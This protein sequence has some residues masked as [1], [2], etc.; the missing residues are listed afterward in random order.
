MD[1]TTPQPQMSS[2]FTPTAAPM[3]QDEWRQ[4]YWYNSMQMITVINPKDEEWPFMV[5]GRHYVIGPR[6]Q[7]RFPGPI[8]NVYL[9]IM[10]KIL[11]QDDDRLG[12]M[13]DPNLR[14]IYYDKLTIDVEDLVPQASAVP[15]YM[16]PASPQQPKQERAP[17]DSAMGERASDI[18][19]DAPPP[20]PSF[21]EPRPTTPAGKVQEP[22]EST[23]GKAEEKSF[24][25]DGSTYKMVV[26]ANGNRLHYKNG[27]LVSSADYN[28]A[29][30]ML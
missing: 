17:W 8:A 21:P 7:E 27:K 26:A 14:K 22:K 5:E 6:G 1:S 16:R 10:S 29:A 18:V 9:D 3:T 15:A 11:A 20:A 30:S 2:N 28:K 19:P 13:G 25:L 12:Y 4:T 23:S 24:E